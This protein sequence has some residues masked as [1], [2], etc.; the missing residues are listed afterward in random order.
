M[1][2]LDASSARANPASR[3]HSRS[4]EVVEDPR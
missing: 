3:T 1:A 2:R 4:L